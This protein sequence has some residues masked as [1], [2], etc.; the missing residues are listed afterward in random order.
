MSHRYRQSSLSAVGITLL[1]QLTESDQ[2]L[3]AQLLLIIN[4][5]PGC[6]YCEQNKSGLS[7]DISSG[8]F[9]SSV[10]E[11]S[12]GLQAKQIFGYL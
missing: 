2:L 12:S 1:P 7:S 11:M 6:L 8:G 9:T 4:A 3:K 5:L 10:L